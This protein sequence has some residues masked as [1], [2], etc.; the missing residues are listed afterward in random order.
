LQTAPS[1]TGT[2]THLP[3]ATSPYTHSLTAAQQFFRLKKN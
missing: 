1:S 3:G 2:F